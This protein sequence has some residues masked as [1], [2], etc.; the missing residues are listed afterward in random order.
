MSGTKKDRFHIAMAGVSSLGTGRKSKT[1]SLK[2]SA[3]RG[4][5]PTSK[6]AGSRK[7]ARARRL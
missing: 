4:A 2:S 3:R 5:G 6:S 7:E 1:V